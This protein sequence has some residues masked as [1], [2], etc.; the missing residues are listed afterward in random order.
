[1]DY[2]PSFSRDGKWILFTSERQGS[3]DIYRVHPDGTG[4]DRLTD[5]PA[6]D[7]QAALSPD[8]SLLAFVSTRGAGT[9]DIWILDLRSRKLRN[10]TRGAGGNFRPKWSPDGRWIAFSSD[11]NTAVRRRSV[12]DFEQVQEAQI[13]LIQPDG[14]GLRRL[15]PEGMFAGSPTWSADGQRVLFYEMTV[16]HATDARFGSFRPNAVSQIVCADVMTG[17]QTELTSGA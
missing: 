8:G 12:R 15:T 13:Y 6:F 11:R 4:L 10:L 7:D 5:N 17:V 2:S 14:A 1:M 16:D 9:A 3:A